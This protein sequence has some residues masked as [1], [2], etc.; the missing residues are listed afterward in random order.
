MSKITEGYLIFLTVAMITAIVAM[1]FLLNS[2]HSSDLV[3][4]TQPD[5]ANLY[6]YQLLRWHD[7]ETNTV[8]YATQDGLSCVKHIETPWLINECESSKDTREDAA[9]I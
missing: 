9:R 3:L 8:C 2:N 6:T 5:S 1:E 7:C 4:P